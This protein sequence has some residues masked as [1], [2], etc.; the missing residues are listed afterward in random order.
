MQTCCRSRGP[1]LLSKLLFNFTQCFQHHQIFH[2]HRQT[3]CRTS[4]K[5]FSSARDGL[6]LLSA[7][8]K[9][10]TVLLSSYMG[11]TKRKAPSSCCQYRRPEDKPCMCRCYMIACVNTSCARLD[12]P[13]RCSVVGAV[14]PSSCG[15]QKMSPVRWSAAHKEQSA[16]YCCGGQM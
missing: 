1:S 14:L 2:L 9:T 13:L 11:E 8:N 5:C 16:L 12:P 15:W 3:R 4:L 6:R 10:R 7:W